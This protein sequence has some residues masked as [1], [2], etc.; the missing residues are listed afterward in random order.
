ME[1]KIIQS[2]ESDKPSSSN[3]QDDNATI[4]NTTKKFKCLTCP[5]T[6]ASRSGL[7]QHNKI[8]LGEK[9][10]ACSTCDRRFT[11]KWD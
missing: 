3:N 10:F 5:K 11:T 9:T 8:H 1:D 7:N 6:S 4:R 2:L